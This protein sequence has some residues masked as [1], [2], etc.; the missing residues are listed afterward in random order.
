MGWAGKAF[1]VGDALEGL[2]MLSL[3]YSPNVDVAYLAAFWLGFLL[4]FINTTWLTTAQL[5]VPSEMQGRYF[6]VDQLGSFATIPLGQVAGGFIIATHGVQLAYEVS[7]LGMLATA[8]IFAC[9]SSTRRLG[10]PSLGDGG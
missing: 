7:G 10:I 6:G 9:F 5:T 8:L 3:V 2:V 1:V 4:G